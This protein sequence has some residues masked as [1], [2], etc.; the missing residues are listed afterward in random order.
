[1]RPGADDDDTDEGHGAEHAAEEERRGPAVGGRVRSTGVA[2]IPGVPRGGGAWRP[3]VRGCGCPTTGALPGLRRGPCRARRT[4]RGWTARASGTSPSWTWS[5]R[6]RA[7]LSRHEATLK[8]GDAAGRGRLRRPRPAPGAAAEG[9]PGHR[10]RPARRDHGARQA[11]ASGRTPPRAPPRR[12]APDERRAGHGRRAARRADLRARCGAR[13]ARPRDPAP[14]PGTGTARGCSS[15]S[16][17]SPFGV[18]LPAVCWAS[19]GGSCLSSRVPVALGAAVHWYRRPSR[20]ASNPGSEPRSLD[21]SAPT[22]VRA[23]RRRGGT[24]GPGA[25][26]PPWR[27]PRRPAA[28][29]PPG[30]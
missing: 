6:A 23:A 27:A 18:G 12:R 15:R 29:S 21:T 3:R 5:T 19:R 11:T 24:A 1:M 10:D 8:D 13:S 28:T 9:R 20:S 30:A 14:S 26:P 22:G 2:L 16:S 17:P 4:R 7:R 25:R